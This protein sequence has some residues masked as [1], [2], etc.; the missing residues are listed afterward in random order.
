MKP[1]NLAINWY[2]FVGLAVLLWQVSV[3]SNKRNEN[4]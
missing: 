3:Q 4:A 2:I 1:Q